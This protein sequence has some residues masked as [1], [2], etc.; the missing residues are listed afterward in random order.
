VTAV[1]SMC[2]S[3][4]E[5]TGV[6]GSTC[7][8]GGVRRRRGLQP[9]HGDIARSSELGSFTAGQ[10]GSGCKESKNGSPGGSVYARWRVAEVRRG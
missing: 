9:N 2:E 10:G 7:A 8:G 1:T 5:V 4:S 6:G 3:S